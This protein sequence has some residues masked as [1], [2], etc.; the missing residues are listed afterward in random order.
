MREGQGFLGGENGLCKGP[1]VG[2]SRGKV[3]QWLG[4][5]GRVVGGEEEGPGVRPG[6]L[7]QSEE[8][9]Y[10]CGSNG[11]PEEGPACLRVCVCVPACGGGPQVSSLR[12]LCS[13]TPVGVFVG[14]GPWPHVGGTSLGEG[15]W[16]Q[17]SLWGLGGPCC[18]VPVI[19][20]RLGDL[21]STRAGTV[22][23]AHATCPPA[24]SLACDEGPVSP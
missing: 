3:S 12:S 6:T 18:M 2:C 19:L 16:D 11:K 4:W 20:G 1:E 21:L 5:G 13:Q 9:V 14:E 22:V 24:V 7:G 15:A 23:G 10:T 8:L 17:A